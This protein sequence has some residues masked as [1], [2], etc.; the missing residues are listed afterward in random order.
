MS[1]GYAGKDIGLEIWMHV[2]LADLILMSPHVNCR[3]S[4]P[5]CNSFQEFTLLRLW[6]V[7][8]IMVLL[9]QENGYFLGYCK[10]TVRILL[11]Q[12]CETFLGDYLHSLMT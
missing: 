6:N 3:K 9:L 10:K 2:C 1:L 12:W 8:Q 7:V 4:S 11:Q 5:I